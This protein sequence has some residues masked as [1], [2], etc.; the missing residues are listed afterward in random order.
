MLENSNYKLYND[1]PI[2][3]DRSIHNNRLDIVLLDKT[4]KEAYLIDVAISNSHNIHSTITEKL[5][6]CTDL[7]EKLIG[8]WK[9]K[10]ACIIPPVLST[11]GIIPNK[12]HESFKLLNLRPALYILI[13]KAVIFNICRTVRKFLAEQ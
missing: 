12:L 8:I 9:L 10:T 13:Q 7:K 2:I 5:Q 1:R 3:T 4:I 6:K 11:T